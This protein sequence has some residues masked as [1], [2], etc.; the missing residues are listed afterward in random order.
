MRFHPRHLTNENRR[1]F[2]LVELIITL[3]I[4][5]ILITGLTV[6]IIQVMASNSGSMTHMTA[7][8]EVE[9]AVYWLGR[10]AEMAQTINGTNITAT[11]NFSVASFNASSLTMTWNNEFPYNSNNISSVTY[12]VAG[13]ALQRTFTPQ[14]GSASAIIVVPHLGSATWGYSGNFSFNITSSVSGFRQ[15]T[16]T[17]TIRV[18]AR[19]TP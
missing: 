17:R 8:K 6:G 5:S 9:N 13:G 2:S 14:G 3:A 15:D 1:G 16:E 10:D 11:S 19:T 4:A 18:L 12:N 7:V